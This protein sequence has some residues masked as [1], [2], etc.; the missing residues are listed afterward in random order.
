MQQVRRINEYSDMPRHED[1][2]A[3]TALCGIDCGERRPL[4]IG[5]AR[6]DNAVRSKHGLHQSR[7]I[8]AG[9]RSPAPV[10]RCADKIM[11]KIDRITAM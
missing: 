9:A 2:V 6:A 8:N 11:R 1:Q 10:I 5:V 3:A 7:T 4:L